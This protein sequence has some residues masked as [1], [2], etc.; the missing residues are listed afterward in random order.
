MEI[1]K[2]IG[3]E[4]GNAETGEEGC[5]V[6][7]VRD[8]VQREETDQDANHTENGEKEVQ[9]RQH[10]DADPHGKGEYQFHSRHDEPLPGDASECGE[11]PIAEEPEAEK[12][13]RRCGNE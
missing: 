13:E 7:Q 8:L 12:E 5:D 3:D 11:G 4:G 10:E 9:K 6:K 1:V 2:I